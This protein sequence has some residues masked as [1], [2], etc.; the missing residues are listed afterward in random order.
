M[1]LPAEVLIH[2]ELLGIKGGK[3]TLLQVTQ[4]GYYEVNCTFGERVHRT[5]FPIQGTVLIQRQAED[6]TRVDLE[7][8]R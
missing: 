3:G 7:I 4:D 5:L 2:N 6:L 8:E 1:E